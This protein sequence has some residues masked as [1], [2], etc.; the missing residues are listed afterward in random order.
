MNSSQNE[1]RKIVTVFYWK[2]WTD[3]REI[4]ASL[5]VPAKEGRNFLFLAGP[6]EF[7]LYH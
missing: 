1:L 3:H 5:Y 4:L 7:Y 6:L 2:V